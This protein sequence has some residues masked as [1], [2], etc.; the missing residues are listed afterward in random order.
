MNPEK[1]LSASATLVKHKYFNRWLQFH[2][3]NKKVLRFLVDELYKFKAQGKP[4]ASIKTLIGIVRYNETLKIKGEG[5]YK[6][7]DAFT[8]IY[9]RIITENWPELAYLLIQKKTKNERNL[10]TKVMA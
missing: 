6:I 3:D 9:S 5:E 8:S 4:K 10:K 7:N 1:R 2:R